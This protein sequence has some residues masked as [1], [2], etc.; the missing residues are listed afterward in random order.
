MESSCAV[1]WQPIN[2]IF[3]II[4]SMILNVFTVFLM[5]EYSP[6]HGPAMIYLTK[7]FLWTFRL[8]PSSVI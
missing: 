6:L 2:I 3:S 1:L 4:F 7:Y 8:F 5:S